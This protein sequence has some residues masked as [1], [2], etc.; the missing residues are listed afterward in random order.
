V[1]ACLY[2]MYMN[3]AY[4]VH[5]VL[6]FLDTRRR[7]RPYGVAVGGRPNVVNEVGQVSPAAPPRQHGDAFG[8]CPVVGDGVWHHDRRAGGADAGGDAARSGVSGSDAKQGACLA[9]CW[10]FR[11]RRRRGAG[12]ASR[13]WLVVAA[14]VHLAETTSHLVHIPSSATASGITTGRR[15]RR[16]APRPTHRWYRCRWERC[17]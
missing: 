16:R 12:S 3:Y 10:S 9:S 13:K 2:S 4:T 8:A 17:V 7:R 15:R 5:V 6:F 1:S 11:R 14:V